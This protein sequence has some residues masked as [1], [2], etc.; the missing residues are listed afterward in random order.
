MLCRCTSAQ[1]LENAGHAPG[2]RFHVPPP[3]AAPAANGSDKYPIADALG[4]LV[5]ARAHCPPDLAA[6]ITAYLVP[7]A[8]DRVSD[9]RPKE[10]PAAADERPA[11]PPPA[12][13][14]FARM[15]GTA[16]GERL[17]VGPA[18]PTPPPPAPTFTWPP[19]RQTVSPPYS[20]GCAHPG[21]RLQHNGR[22]A[23]CLDC[24]TEFPGFV[25]RS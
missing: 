20:N 11:T 4:L 15:P 12:I 25:I 7:P 14:A 2:C 17:Q 18:M 19:A 1:L 8:A 23:T 5:R 24:A 6:E 10:E 3:A 22:D 13:E 9:E 21:T 16:G